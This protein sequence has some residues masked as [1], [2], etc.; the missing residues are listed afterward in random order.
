M[1]SLRS[2]SLFALACTAITSAAPANVA[3]QVPGLPVPDILPGNLLGSVGSLS[4]VGHIV[5][6]P[7]VR[8]VAAKPV[9][10]IF[11]EATIALGP[12]VAE[13][14]A[15]VKVA[16][17][18]DVKIV[19]EHL[20]AVVAILK[21]VLAD[22]KLVVVAE[23][24]LTF[25][26]VVYTA[27]TLAVVVYGLVELVVDVLHTVVLVVG[28]VDVVLGPLIIQIGVLLAQILSVVIVV[29]VGLQISLAVLVKAIVIDIDFLKY[30]QILVVLGLKA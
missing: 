12:I 28:F 4:D 9:P 16:A 18:V 11:H 20:G 30:T 8:G 26:G 6:T 17:D 23:G 19:G 22:V 14:K 1:F 2:I 3:R 25:E 21:G 5:P 27:D 13:L 29:V 24:Y 10:Q 15:D 7:N